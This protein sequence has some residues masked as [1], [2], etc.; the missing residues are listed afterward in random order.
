MNA[1]GLCPV[2]GISTDPSDPFNNHNSNVVNYNFGL[3]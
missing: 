2:N 1:Q 3:A